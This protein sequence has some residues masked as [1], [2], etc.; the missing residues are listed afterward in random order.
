MADDLDL[1]KL[2]ALALY[3]WQNLPG[4][5][6]DP[7]F[8]KV[9]LLC[10]FDGADASTAFVDESMFANALTTV[11]N[12]QV[13]TAQFKFGTASALFDG[14]GDAI[15]T[16][17]SIRWQL[18]S[19]NAAPW[20]VECWVRFNTLAGDQSLVSQWVSGQLA[21][22]VR[23]NITTNEIQFAWS[24]TGSDNFTVITSSAGLSVNTW[25]HVA[26]DKDAT[27]KIRVYVGGTMRGSSTPANSAINNSSA[28]LTIGGESGG[29][30]RGVNGWLDEV[31]ITKGMARYAN[32]AG[33]A[34]PTKQ[35]PRGFADTDP[36]YPPVGPTARPRRVQNVN[37]R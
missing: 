13:D 11:G 31:R 24:T 6:D 23:K 33:F 16:P 14:T 30:L 27:G 9:V 7:D 1:D 20:T 32:D 5:D 17:D 36:I 28:V 21:W 37:Y 35:F 4:L 10:G 12:A 3:R 29:T 18:G 22:H 34:V 26:V 19:T 8:G 2:Y 25:Y 15:T